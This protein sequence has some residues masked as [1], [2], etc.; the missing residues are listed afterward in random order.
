MS[1]ASALRGDTYTT[2][3]GSSSCAVESPASRKS[4]SMQTRNAASVLPEPV[5]A[6][7]RVSTPL[8]MAGHPS[9]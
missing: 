5:G 9:A 7:I 2:R 8:A 4:R 3:V 1:A 6:A